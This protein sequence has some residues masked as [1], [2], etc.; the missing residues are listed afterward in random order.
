MLKSFADNQ[1]VQDGKVR[2]KSISV[3]DLYEVLMAYCVSVSNLCVNFQWPLGDN[4]LENFWH[5]GLEMELQT[6][7]DYFYDRIQIL[8]TWD[9]SFWLSN[10]NPSLHPVKLKL[11]LNGEVCPKNRIVWSVLWHDHNMIAD[12]LTWQSVRTIMLI[13]ECTFSC[14]EA[15]PAVALLRGLLQHWGWVRSPI[16]CIAS[17]HPL[18]L[19]NPTPPLPDQS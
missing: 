10:Y 12:D 4:I 5:F 15:M 11:R 16:H 14:V 9:I 17:Q 6:F 2:M 1:A 7:F 19:G 3:N 18:L 13:H 8:K